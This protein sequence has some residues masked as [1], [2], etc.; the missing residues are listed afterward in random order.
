MSGLPGVGSHVVV[1]KE[2]KME[3]FLMDFSIPTFAW[4]G[5]AVNASWPSAGKLSNRNPGG[6]TE[7]LCSFGGWSV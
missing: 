6:R 7:E 3:A 2:Q 1:K 5:A 4:V